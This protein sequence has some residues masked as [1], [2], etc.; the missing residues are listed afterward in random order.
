MKEFISS[1]FGSMIFRRVCHLVSKFFEYFF[2]LV[3][4]WAENDEVLELDLW[5]ISVK[6]WWDNHRARY[7]DC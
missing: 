2:V 1:A 4:K 5:N 6:D 7:S 3:S